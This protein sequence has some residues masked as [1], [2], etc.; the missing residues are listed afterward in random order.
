VIRGEVKVKICGLTGLADAL[1][2]A[3]LGADF[4]GFVF[5]PSPRQLHLEEA[6]KFWGDLPPAV[7]RVGVFRDQTAREVGRI[8]ER[9]PLG[10]LQFHGRESPAVCRSF[11]LPVIKAVSCR[12]R[13]DLRML[14]LYR[15]VAEYFLVDLPKEDATKRSLPLDI[16]RAALE[17]GRPVFLAGGLTGRSVGALLR[18][19]RP[20]AV[21][22]ARGVEREPGRKDLRKMEEFMRR[23][24]ASSDTIAGERA[25]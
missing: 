7:P 24:R 23:V 21:D 10:Y 19:V 18:Q 17:L 22:V 16:A 2:A 11:G 1:G 6:V 13:K 12:D 9:L 25:E 3:A 4:L 8:V 5:A 14:E 15:D 20:F